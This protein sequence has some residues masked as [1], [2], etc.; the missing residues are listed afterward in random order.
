MQQE[1]QAVAQ[2]YTAL[3]AVT[4]VMH[5]LT[6]ILLLAGGIMTLKR[7]QKGT[8]ILTI[9]CVLAICTR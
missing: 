5:L 2:E 7:N 8:G 1:I 4:V 6:A 3:S 9:G